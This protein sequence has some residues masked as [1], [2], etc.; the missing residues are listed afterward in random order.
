MTDFEKQFEQIVAGLNIDDQSNT[1][2]KQTL[3]K[4]MLD[5]CKDAPSETTA[6]RIQPVWSKI[7]K[8]RMTQ[9]TSAAAILI[10]ALV[11]IHFLIGKGTTVEDIDALLQTLPAVVARLRALA[12]TRSDV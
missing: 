6:I 4:Q 12:P 7:M 1:E 9:L 8:N 2:H 3:R 11:S 5:A 10:A